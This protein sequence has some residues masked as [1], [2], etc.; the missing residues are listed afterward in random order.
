MLDIPARTVYI[1]PEVYEQ[2]NCRARLERVLPHVRCSDHRPY[3]EAGRK[4]VAA[5]GRRRHGKDEFGDD[6]VLIFTTHEPGRAGWYYHWRDEAAAHGGACQPALE[7]NLIDGC[8]FR[9][10]YC[11]F[12]RT[13][14]FSLDAERLLAGLDEQFARH[15]RQRLYK[16]SNMTDLPTFE[17]ELD[18]VAPLVHRFA[19]EPDRYLMLFT[20]SNNVGFLA[21]LAH[22]GHTIISWSLTCD[23]VSREVDRRTANLR[24]RIEAMRQMQAAGYLVRARLSPILPVRDW[25]REYAELFAALFARVRPDLV[26]L[27]LLGWMGVDDLT[28]IM[29][30]A[31]LDPEAL[32]GAKAAAK[33]L[34]KVTWGPF[35][36]ATHEEVYRFC[37]ETVKSLSPG[38]PVSVCHGTPATWAAL[39]GLMQ[40]TPT[41]YICNCGPD[42]APGGEV[43]D[44]W[45]PAAAAKPAAAAPH[46][47]P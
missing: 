18:V 3:D 31:R 32:A 35:T 24:E 23:T 26:T 28:A 41:R 11:G 8:P 33:D 19:R 10:A 39:G 29:D 37:I 25:R 5:I 4:D 46:E 20:K 34:A 44:K 36:Q 6:A 2:P 16:Y 14:H 9:C 43:Y 38:T 15:P 47:R 1:A 21:G 40:M 13:I 45:H 30:P 27:E 42:S 22:G 17:P 12:G 7:L